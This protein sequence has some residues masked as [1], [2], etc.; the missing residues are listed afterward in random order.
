MARRGLTH[1]DRVLSKFEGAL[2]VSPADHTELVW[3]ETRTSQAVSSKRIPAHEPRIET[4]V[5]VRVLEQQRL[6]HHRT[7]SYEPQVLEDAVRSAC[8]QARLQ[9]PLNRWRAPIDRRLPDLSGSDLFEPGLGALSPKEGRELLLS[10]LKKEERGQLEWTQG[11]VAV[12]SA[13]GLRRRAQVTSATL[14]VSAGQ[15]AEAG[16]ARTCARTLQR[17]DLEGTVERARQRRCSVGSL[18]LE[19][20]AGSTPAVLSPEATTA[21]LEKL[22][23]LVLAPTLENREA[24]FQ[25]C[26]GSRLSPAINLYD[27]GGDLAGM[28]FPFDLKGAPKLP[29]WLVREGVVQP[30]PRGSRTPEDQLGSFS[31]GGGEVRCSNLVLRPGQAGEEELLR[32]AEKGTWV[33]S[34][35]HFDWTDPSRL[36]VRCR[37]RGLRRIRGGCLAEA[38]PDRILETSLEDLLGRVL[39]AGNTAVSRALGSGVFGGTT[40]PALLL[41]RLSWKP[42]AQSQ[43]ERLRRTTV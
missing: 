12:A 24:F 27:D 36:G 10:V 4:T 22:S 13:Q 20:V 26:G 17:L 16:T 11:Q 14:F 38:L 6:G 1:L 40:A 18:A 19:D 25:R 28:P 41:E 32:A 29:L 30:M 23:N 42:P 15:G 33:S 43:R 8:A 39:K 34:F 9:A 3:I 5:L 2:D 21:F 35:S 7:G 31:A 37:A